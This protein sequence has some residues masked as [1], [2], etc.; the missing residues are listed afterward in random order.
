[1]TLESMESSVRQ[2][3]AEFE[4]L[5]TAHRPALWQFCF[6]LTGSA[7]DAEDLVQ[8]TLAKAFAR[9]AHFWQP[10]ETRPYLF[11]IASNAYIDSMRRRRLSTQDLESTPE[12]SGPATDIGETWGAIE[13]LV[14]LLPPRQRIVVLLTQVFEFTASEVG[15]MLSMTEGAVKSA[16]YRARETLKA[17]SIEAGNTGTCL[18]KRASS[19]VVARYLDAFNRR[20]PEAILALLDPEVTGDIIGVG[21]EYGR[22]V[23]RKNSVSE[24]AADPQPMWAEPGLLEESPVVFVFYRTQEHEKALAW[25]IELKVSEDLI[26]SVRTFVFTPDFIR[27]VAQLLGLPSHLL[28]Y[29]YN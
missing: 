17:Q 23:V 10:L 22:E 7:W 15:A 5:V 13:V 21:E 28:G 24:W 27:H 20:D 1:M 16:L 12:P 6:R 29:R 14:Q 8:E 19:A 25:V 26:T 3:R 11:R 9:L 4:E 2:L 18:L